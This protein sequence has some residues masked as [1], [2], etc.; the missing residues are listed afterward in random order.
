MGAA[1]P[2]A[3]VDGVAGAWYGKTPGLDRSGDV[4]KHANAMGAGPNGGVVLF[5]GD[6]PTRQVVHAGLR[7]PVHLRGRLHAR[8]LPGRP[9]GRARPRR[10]RL[11]AVPLRR[12]PGSG[13][14]I[15][16]AVADG[17]GTV[18]LDPDRHHPSDPTSVGL[19][20]QPWHHQPLATVGAARRAEPGER[21][22]CS[23]R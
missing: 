2:Y 17:I 4:L 23:D 19:D 15:V 16:T 8:A 18:D 20:G 9:A 10:A 14:K 22:S 7:Q 13:L 11:P 12:L 21:W 1:I 6:D 5:C 3:D